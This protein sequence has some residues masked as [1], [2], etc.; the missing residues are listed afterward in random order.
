MSYFLSASLSFAFGACARDAVTLLFLTGGASHTSS[1]TGAA[2]TL[3]VT[4]AT[5][6][7]G[8]AIPSGPGGTVVG[9][10]V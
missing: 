6:G 1:V 5:G 4:G 10:T 3:S 2:D 9:D 8:A 7:A